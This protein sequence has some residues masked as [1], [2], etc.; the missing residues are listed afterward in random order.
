[1][2]AFDSGRGG[3]QTYRRGR[4][5]GGRTRDAATPTVVCDRDLW[6]P[7]GAGG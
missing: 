5:A 2:S 6:D 3:K 1:M 4:N 7:K